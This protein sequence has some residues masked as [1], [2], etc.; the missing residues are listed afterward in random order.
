MTIVDGPKPGGL[1]VVRIG[2]ASQTVAERDQRITALR[3]RSDVID[4][5][6]SK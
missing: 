1:F 5:V 2:S 4:L 3:A 6:L